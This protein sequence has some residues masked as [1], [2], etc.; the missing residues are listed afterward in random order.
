[1]LCCRIA[2]PIAVALLLV[3]G[4][5]FTLEADDWP[6]W[7]GPH[8]DGVCDEAGLL[9]KLPAEGLKVRWRVPVGWGYSSP[10]VAEGR[11]YL[12]DSE[13]MKPKA[14]ERLLCRDEATGKEIWTHAYDV[15]YEDWA[16]DPTQEIGPVAT[17]IVQNGKVYTLGRLNDLFCLD[18]RRGDILWKANLG[19]AYGAKFSPGM[20]SPLIEGELL[21]LLIGGKP[22]AGVVALNKDTGMEAWKA[23]DETLT[24]SSP[25]VIASGG[26]RQLIVWT[27][28]SLT[29]LDPATGAVWW[30]QRLLTS[31]DYA[32][33][34]PVFHADRLLL[35]GLMFQLDADKPAARVL[36]PA[37]SAPARRI[38]S[39]T[40]TPMF[41]GGF[42]YSA[43][44]SGELICVDAD[45]GKQVW[46][47]DKVTD[48]KNGASIHIT[49]NGQTA[50]LYTNKGELIRARLTPEGYHELSR[51]AVIEPTMP[52]GG[53]NVVWAPPAYANRHIFARSGKE[54]VCA[55]LGDAP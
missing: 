53:R 26:K 29:S 36:W 30:R 4:L 37:S 6:Q 14:R 46:E 21:I 48:M 51:T 18:T 52:F 42:V 24:F 43:R 17:P 27:Q 12:A 22:G 1:M 45:T 25:I 54:L 20:P 7:R 33:S 41:R 16:F 34:T 19:T 31:S 9:E 44:S 32:V 10:V 28:E 40:S 47:T 8:R 35:G 49:P 2:S 55:S 23:L 39:N 5:S 50:L 11:V 13:L 3:P 38:Y 15:A